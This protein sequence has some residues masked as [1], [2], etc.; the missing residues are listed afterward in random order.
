[1]TRKPI[2]ALAITAMTVAGGVL[3]AYWLGFLPLGDDIRV[4]GAVVT[5][6]SGDAMT[7]WCYQP[8]C[9]I[10]L[11]GYDGTVEILNC[12]SGSEVTGVDGI[13]HIDGTSLTLIASGGTVNVFITPPAKDSFTFA[14]MGDSQGHNEVLAEI[15]S[16]LGGCD[17]ALLCG[18]LTPTGRAS[19]FVPFQEV[20]NCSTVP[21]YMTVGNHDVKT[22]GATEYISRFGPV[23]YDFSYGGVTFAV[24]DSS[25]LNVTESQVDWMRDVFPDDGKRVIMTHVPCYDPFGDDHTLSPESCERVLGF[26]EYDEIDAV[27]TGHIHAFNHT[28]IG[29]TDFVISGGAGA[30]LTDGE[31]HYVN[32][33]VN[34][35]AGFVFEKH[36]VIMEMTTPP[37]VSV[38]GRDGGLYNMTFGDIAAQPVLEGSSSFENFF[39]NI[40]GEGYYEGVA[41]STLVDLAGGMQEGDMLRVTATDGYYQ[42]FGYLNVYPDSTWLELQGPMVLAM[43]LDNVSVPEWADGPKLVMLAPDGLY[44]NEDCEA[45]S[46]EG[47]GYSEYPSA[48]GRWVKCVSVIQVI[49]CT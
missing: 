6:R 21:I 34:G 47:Q 42:D 32:V 26:A 15:L 44:S 46:Y 25:D 1:M 20:L 31:H 19:E 40:G 16:R 29:D 14:V 7:I 39:G 17:F 8:G 3:A 22:D 24:L 37:H 28:V 23:Q 38:V 35:S 43:A 36:D 30:T 27:F 12:V 10:T 4:E 13:D 11:K 33:T 18:D 41:V 2:A 48:G 9:S 49:P 5:Y 45:T